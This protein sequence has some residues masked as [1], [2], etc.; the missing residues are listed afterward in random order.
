MYDIDGW[1]GGSG[2]STSTL[3]I[4]PT[5]SAREEPFTQSSNTTRYDPLGCLKPSPPAYKFL[6]EYAHYLAPAWHSV[7]PGLTSLGQLT[8][9]HP[10]VSR[11]LSRLSAI[12][13]AEGRREPN[14]KWYSRT[15]RDWT[16]NDVL[17]LT[18]DEGNEVI[19]TELQAEC[20]FVLAAL[21]VLHHPTHP[22]HFTLWGREW[23]P[24]TAE[25]VHKMLRE[26]HFFC[27][28]RV[29]LPGQFSALTPH[30]YAL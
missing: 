7:A 2:A 23:A 9:S 14:E 22:K 18:D 27:T 28:R 24:K 25:R 16:V 19:L 30:T 8:P 5:S 13:S 12:S 29:R 26:C 17:D 10:I 21:K 1:S 15:Q 11:L 4:F 20:V 6:P 3:D